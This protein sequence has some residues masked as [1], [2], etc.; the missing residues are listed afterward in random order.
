MGHLIFLSKD[1]LRSICVFS[2]GFKY[3]EAKEVYKPPFR[4]E[5][6]KTVNSI[7]SRFSQTKLYANLLTKTNEARE[8][9][10]KISHL[11]IESS[12]FISPL[13]SA[14]PQ[15]LFLVLLFEI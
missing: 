4:R 13:P 9:L 2:V 12:I 11:T 6:H 10:T 14:P 1:Y 8:R 15:P 3:T 5:T 7:M